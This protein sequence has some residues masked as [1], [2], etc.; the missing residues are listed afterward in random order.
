[1]AR[2][3]GGTRLLAQSRYLVLGLMFA[4]C[5]YVTE[6]PL[7][8]LILPEIAGDLGVGSTHLEMIANAYGISVAV[9]VIASGWLGDRFGLRS[10]ILSGIGLFGLGALICSLSWEFDVLIAGRVIQG[11]GGGLFSP[12]IPVALARLAP[13]R[14]GRSLAIWNTVIGLVIASVPLL[15][16]P[17]LETHG[18]RAVMGVLGLVALAACS[19]LSVN[20]RRIAGPAPTLERDQNF[21]GDVRFLPFLLIYVAL[22]Y[23]TMLLF[24]FWAPIQMDRPDLPS[25]LTGTLLSLSWFFFGAIG[26]LIRRSIDTTRVLHYILLS[27][28]VLCAGW[29]VFL[30]SG[31]SLVRMIAAGCMVGAGL[32]LGNAPSTLLILRHAPPGRSSLAISLDVT[33]ARLGAVLIIAL[34]GSVTDRLNMA[35][36]LGVICLLN[37]LVAL[38]LVRPYVPRPRVR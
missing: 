29:M 15:S 12:L 35:L 22:N 27:P 1:M 20:H 7:V 5:V 19:T 4:G 23:G 3:E 13:D 26:F 25:M 34:L 2:L 24:L 37:L 17:I 28:L 31:D 38:P 14:P 18:W 11:I 30:W 6:I 36:G 33:F 16:V 9:A 32:G 21:S 10:V 8:N